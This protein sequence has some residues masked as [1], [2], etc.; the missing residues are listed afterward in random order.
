MGEEEDGR[1]AFV[2]LHDLVRR[3]QRLVWL[4]LVELDESKN[5][6]HPHA[7]LL[8]HCSAAPGPFSRRY[9]GRSLCGDTS[10]EPRHAVLR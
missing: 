7:V 2:V 8:M 1:H 5:G 9:H 6:H 10:A 3:S 4:Q